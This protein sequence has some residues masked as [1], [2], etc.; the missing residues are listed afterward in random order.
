MAMTVLEAIHAR[1][2][3]DETLVALL[4]A[5]RVSTG[6]S[7][8]P[9][10]PRAVLGKM[11]DQS[12]S[13]CN[14]GSQVSVIGVR[15]EAFHHDYSAAVAVIERLKA[16]LDRAD[17]ALDTGDKVVA[18]RRAGDSELQQDDGVWQMVLDLE[19]LVHLVPRT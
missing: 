3:A 1:W 16:V 12:L 8:A 11:S 13:A 6:M 19:C 17:F 18:V 9:D 2:A 5:D 7:A 4:P 14:D 15:I 10:L